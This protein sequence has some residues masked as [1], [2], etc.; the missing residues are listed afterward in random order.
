[1]LRNRMCIPKSRFKNMLLGVPTAAQWVKNP[2]SIHEDV[3]LIPGL[4]Q[5]V[6]DPALPWLWRRPAAVA[7]ILPVAQELP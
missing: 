6:K 1:M 5:W 7:Q 2:I 4:T 3:C